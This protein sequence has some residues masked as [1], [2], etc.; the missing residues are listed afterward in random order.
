M[1]RY[2]TIKKASKILDL[3]PDTLRRWDRV[4]KLKTRHHPVNKYRLY[5]IREIE[6]LKSKIT[7]EYGF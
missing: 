4:G 7:G 6:K 2:I 5:T 1:K 3:H